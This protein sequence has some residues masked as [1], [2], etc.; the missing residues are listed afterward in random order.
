MNKNN[1]N[2][3]RLFGIK[4]EFSIICSWCRL[5]IRYESA[6]FVATCISCI[7]MASRQ[8]CSRLLINRVDNIPMY[9][10]QIDAAT[11][12]KSTLFFTS[13]ARIQRNGRF[14][15]PL[16]FSCFAWNYHQSKAN[17]PYLISYLL[18][19][20]LRLVPLVRQVCSGYENTYFTHVD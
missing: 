10:Y 13:I 11:K 5:A 8:A 4:F 17:S 6:V 18:N 15:V 1:S 9:S 2:N 3:L 20:V 12:I 7:T 16:A 19:S 14:S